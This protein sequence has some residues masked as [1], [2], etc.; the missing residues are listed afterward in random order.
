MPSPTQAARTPSSAPS[1]PKNRIRGSRVN[2]TTRTGPS[3]DLS[4]IARPACGH[5]YDKTASARLVYPNGLSSNFTYDEL[6]RVKALNNYQYQLG[7]TGNRTSATEPNGR[8]LNWTYD[9]IYRLTNE[10]VTLDPRS[11]NG[12]VNYGLDPVG[13]RLSEDSTIPGI[14]T[15]SATFDANDRLSTETYDNNGNTTVS[16]ARTFAYDFE[17]RLKSM[18]NSVSGVT[19]R[20]LVDDL[21]PTHYAQVVEELTGTT[22]TRSY[23]FGLQRI[24]QNQPINTTWTPGFYG[25]DGGYSVRTLTD[26]TGAVTDT[27]D[28]DA[29]GNAVNTTGTTPNVYLY[30]GEQY[31]SDLGL[32][33]LRARYFNPLTGRFVTRDTYPVNPSD[34]GTLHRYLYGRSDPVNRLDRAGKADVLEYIMPLAFL[35]T[36]VVIYELEATRQNISCTWGT[37]NGLLLMGSVQTNHMTDRARELI[38]AGKFKTLCEALQFLYDNAPDSATRKAAE[39]AL[40]F[41]CCKNR[42]KGRR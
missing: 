7:P 18:N 2:F 16:G 1:L 28:Y 29:W 25:Y 15:G 12:T 42:G 14:P 17:N 40:K 11:K 37:A 5:A 21:N 32:Y 36:A 19:T 4:P 10:T 34:S 27:Y 22:V 6:N 35:T 9:G 24:S 33:Y 31:D 30:R 3:S 13:N 8:A 41:A 23:T 39:Q 38:Q 26:A 20:Y